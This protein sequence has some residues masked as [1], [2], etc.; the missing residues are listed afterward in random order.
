MRLLGDGTTRPV[1]VLTGLHLV[2]DATCN[3]PGT[4]TLFSTHYDLT[5]GNH[6]LDQ[7]E[8]SGVGDLNIVF[9]ESGYSIFP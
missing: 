2:G 6:T 1:I 5:V 4:G 8:K 3:A 7:H 9:T